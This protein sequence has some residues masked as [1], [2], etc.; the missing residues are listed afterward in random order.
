MPDWLGFVRGV[1]DSP[2]LTLNLSREVLQQ[3]RQLRFIADSLRKKILADFKK[4]LKSDREGYEKFFKELGEGIKYG[5]YENFGEK[6]DELKDLVVFGSSTEK[7][8]VT[9]AEYVSRMKEGQEGIYYACGE[10][11]DKIDAQPQ[12][13]KLK[14]DGYEIQIGRAHV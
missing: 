5:V 8:A 1:V 2:D 9:L 7:K 10:S 13:E 3:D 4:W 6:K 14:S 11:A 12:L